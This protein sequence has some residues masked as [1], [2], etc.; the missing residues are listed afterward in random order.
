MTTFTA[1][2]P[3]D[4]LANNACKSLSLEFTPAWLSYRGNAR[5]R[6]LFLYL[7][8]PPKPVG[9]LLTTSIHGDVA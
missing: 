2:I 9:Q 4:L 6:R 1:E 3:S 8:A 7:R 5:K